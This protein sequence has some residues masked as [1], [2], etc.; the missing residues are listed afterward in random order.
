MADA[1][2]LHLA[3]ASPNSR[4]ALPWQMRAWSAAGS[5]SDSMTAMVERM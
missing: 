3:G 5:P 2:V 1:A 4:S